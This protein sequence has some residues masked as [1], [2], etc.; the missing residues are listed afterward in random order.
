MYRV[1]ICMIQMERRFVILWYLLTYLPAV[2][3]H[4]N[5]IVIYNLVA[6]HTI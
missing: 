1:D 6:T 5:Y 2:K 4:I 3:V